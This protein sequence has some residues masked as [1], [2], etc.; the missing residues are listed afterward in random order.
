MYGRRVHEVE[1]R[2]L[3]SGFAMPEAPLWDHGSQSLLV[4]DVQ[5]GGVWS[6]T[7]GR[8]NLLVPH[9]RGIGGLARELRGGLIVSGKNLSLKS[10]EGN[11]VLATPAG[12]SPTARFNDLTVSDS[13]RIYV[14]SID[15]EPGGRVKQPGNLVMIDTDGSE[16]VVA[17]GIQK[18]NGLGFSPDGRW[19]YHVDTGVRSVWCYEVHPSGSLSARRPLVQWDSGIPDGLAVATD[20]SIWVA[21]ADLN[22]RGYLAVLSPVGEELRWIPT[23]ERSVTSLCFGGP[24]LRSVFVTVG[25]AYDPTARGGRVDVFRSDTAGLPR[26]LARIA[27]DRN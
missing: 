7:D 14:G 27:L 22:D 6:V 23:R 1:W 2:A 10:A 20:G 9:R 5:A 18:T 15:A 17:T 26:P 21:V 25:G 8:K 19:L 12:G 3:A 13:G 24:D 11:I 4:T 16:S